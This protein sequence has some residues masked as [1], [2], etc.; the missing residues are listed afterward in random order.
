VTAYTTVRGS[1]PASVPFVTVSFV[2][3]TQ[4]PGAGTVPAHLELWFHSQ[5]QGVAENVTVTM[6]TPSVQVWNDFTGRQ[7]FPSQAGTSPTA[8]DV[9][10]WIIPWKDL[11]PEVSFPAYLRLVFSTEQTKVDIVGLPPVGSGT[12]G[13]PM[14][15]L[16]PLAD[17]I[18]MSGVRY[19]G[20]EGTTIVSFARIASLTQGIV[21]E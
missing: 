21:N 1:P 9:N 7:V 19:V 15:V 10:I 3:L 17:W 5:P 20:W 4:T 6:N 14:P 16:K 8:Q 13:S 2:P 18:K 11:I 12:A